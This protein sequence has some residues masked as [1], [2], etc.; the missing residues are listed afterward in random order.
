MKKIIIFLISLFFTQVVF[1]DQQATQALMTDLAKL[2]SVQGQFG[3]TIK[4]AHGAVMQQT[5]GD[6][7]LNRPVSGQT[8]GLFYWNV[9]TDPKQ[10]LIADGKNF[11]FY[12]VS[13]QQVTKQSQS[14]VATQNSP[15]ML[16]SGDLKQ[17]SKQYNISMIT[18][19]SEQKFTLVPIKTAQGSGTFTQLVIIFSAGELKKMQAV[20][21]LENHIEINFSNLKTP[22]PASLFVFKKPAGAEVVQA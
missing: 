10:V 1:A 11:W 4:D 17:I 14:A 8:Q 16:L 9:K 15:A 22:A 18:A 5:K 20:D 7:A 6:F 2:Q 19:N 12:D 21:A 13:L 3:Q